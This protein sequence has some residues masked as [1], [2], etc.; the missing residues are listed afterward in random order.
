L[1]PSR[2]PASSIPRQYLFYFLPSRLKLCNREVGAFSFI[3]PLNALSALPL[4]SVSSIV[5]HGEYQFREY[6][7]LPY[8]PPLYFSNLKSLSS[9]QTRSS[10]QPPFDEPGSLF[11]CL[12]FLTL[13]ISAFSICY[14]EVP[15][16]STRDGSIFSYGFTPLTSAQVQIHFVLK[17]V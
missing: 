17:S 1:R 10:N 2:K 11:L 6:L 7:I 14:S 16:Q 5:S 4:F 12:R 9:G 3:S 15:Y 8:R 13:R